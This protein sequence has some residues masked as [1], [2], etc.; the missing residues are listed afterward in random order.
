MSF[1]LQIDLNSILIE[2]IKGR[3]EKGAFRVH[4][5]RGKV[6]NLEYENLE[7]E[8]VLSRIN[9]KSHWGGWGWGGG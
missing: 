4:V 9:L 6:F 8:K 1:L 3:E 7:S 5:K 2:L